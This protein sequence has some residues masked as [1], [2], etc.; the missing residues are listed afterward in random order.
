MHFQRKREMLLEE[1][2]RTK[3]Q[4]DLMD[5]LRKEIEKK[6]KAQIDLADDL[7]RKMQR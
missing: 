6:K 3:A 7:K 5:N 1:R 4:K 2:K